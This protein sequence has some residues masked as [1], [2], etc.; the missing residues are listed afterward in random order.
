MTEA[1]ETTFQNIKIGITDQNGLELFNGD[2]IK[3]D[4][5]KNVTHMGKIVY[6]YAS[7]CLEYMDNF[8]QTKVIPLNNYAIYCKITKIS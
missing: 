8:G 5:T 1:L 7:F 2:E 4:V 6:Y 3:I